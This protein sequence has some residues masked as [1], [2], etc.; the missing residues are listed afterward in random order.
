MKKTKLFLMGFAALAL[1]ACGP[2]ATPTAAPT[3]PPKPTDAP[4]PAATAAPAATATT[5]KGQAGVPG[6]LTIATT[7][8]TQDSGLLDVLVPLAEKAINAK[9]K[10][11]A[12]GTGQ[13]L[14]L[15]EDGNA[16][17]VLVHARAQED[18]F[19]KKEF[20][21]NRRDVMYNDFVIV[22]PAADPAKFGSFKKASEAFK[23]IAD[24]QAPFASRG[25][26]SGTNTKE[27]EVW[28]AAGVDPKGAWYSSLGQGMGET[29]N[30]SN[31]KGAYT[32]TDRAT[33]L[34]QKSK[35]GGL[36]VVFGGD[37]IDQ[38]PDAILFNPYGVIPVNPARYPQINKDLAEKFAE[39]IT[40]IDTQ[41][42]IASY[43]TDKYGAPLFYP[44]SKQWMDA[45]K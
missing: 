28:K 30:F 41:K 22:G 42:V 3:A 31:E 27:L 4:K 37:K 33:W 18:D 12:V 1:A 20:G 40:S 25:D 17:V 35:L 43:G 5:V 44:Q 39:W 23:A 13:S 19:I 6:V 34:A 38:N 29:L 15:G 36:K 2:A 26:K 14:K 45:N 32:L 8:S 24:A 7:T 11:I 16:D 21:I 10:V 9:I